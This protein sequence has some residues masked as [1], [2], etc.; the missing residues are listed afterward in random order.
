MGSLP[1]IA[2]IPWGTRV[3]CT[4]GVT[5]E[6]G[7][8]GVHSLLLSCWLKKKSTYKVTVASEKKS[9]LNDAKRVLHRNALTSRVQN[10]Q[11]VEQGL[12]AGRSE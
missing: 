10:I 1:S 9:L 4:P 12:R 2:D 11:G 7:M 3:N 8:G 5:P 6:P